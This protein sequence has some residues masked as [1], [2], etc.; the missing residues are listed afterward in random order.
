MMQNIN[1]PEAIQIQIFDVRLKT[2]KHCSVSADFATIPSLAVRPLF[3][4]RN[5]SHY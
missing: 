2:G 3:K 5:D 4:P 1:V